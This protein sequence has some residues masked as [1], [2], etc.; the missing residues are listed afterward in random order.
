MLSKAKL[1]GSDLEISDNSDV[2]TDYE[3]TKR[4]LLPPGNY[5]IIPSRIE[6]SKNES[7]LVR[8]FNDQ[9]VKTM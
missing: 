4:F 2:S 8:I 3:L 6:E 9:E 7:F 5:V 1:Y